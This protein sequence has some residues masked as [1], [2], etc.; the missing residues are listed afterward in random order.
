MKSNTVKAK[1]VGLDVGSKNIKV[2]HLKPAGKDKLK[3]EKWAVLPLPDNVVSP[4]VLAETRM[5]V[6]QGV[7]NEYF[8]KNKSVPRKVVISVA[9][10]SVVIRY[11][12]L[13]Q[14]SR[15]ELEKSIGMEAEP[16]IPFPI[17]EVNLAF[18]VL[19]EVLD[20]GVK[21]NEIAL[22]AARKEVVN[23]RLELMDACKLA[24]QAIDVDVFA[25]ET[26]VGF[27]T[28]AAD[29]VV[30]IVNIGANTTNVGIIEEGTTRVSRDLPMGMS[31]IIQSVKNIQQIDDAKVIDEHLRTDGLIIREEDKE[32]YLD[33]DK[34]DALLFSKNLTSVLKEI[35]AELRKIVDFYYFQKGEQ[36][37]ITKLYLS[38]GGSIIKNLDVYLSEDLKLPVEI[39]DPFKKL[40]NGERVP[41]DVRPLMA[42]ALGLALKK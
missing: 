1:Y 17:V 35:T 42:V 18:D 33:Q 26:A 28:D 41:Q 34:K 27:A 37:P 21:K 19:G 22:V 11:I 29:K 20:E 16:F 31:Y 7:I 4:D 10:S 32:R 24:P 8:A 6:V 2:L 9:G 38:G 12:K 15:D 14:M 40:V 25:L 39:F 13:P 23:G 5:P 36:K 3:V 30:G